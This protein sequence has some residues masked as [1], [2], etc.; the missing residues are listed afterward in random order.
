METKHSHNI[1]YLHLTHFIQLHHAFSNEKSASVFQQWFFIS[2]SS[3]PYTPYKMW[4]T[5]GRV[6]TIYTQRHMAH[7][8]LSLWSHRDALGGSLPLG[9][10]D[11][12]FDVGSRRPRDSISTRISLLYTLVRS[13]L[14][15]GELFRPFF[16]LDCGLGLAVLYN[17]ISLW[18]YRW[19]SGFPRCHLELSAL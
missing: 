18:Y 15:D 16:F 8:T 17:F 4:V 9:S 6:C 19:T 10:E 5:T 11:G 2:A 7:S 1:K 14:V 12:T 13:L 3:P